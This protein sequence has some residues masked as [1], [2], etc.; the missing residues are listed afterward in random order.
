MVGSGSGVSQSIDCLD[1]EFRNRDGCRGFASFFGLV[2]DL[3]GL[4]VA[5]DGQAI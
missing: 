2:F 1:R 3:F 4:A 5:F